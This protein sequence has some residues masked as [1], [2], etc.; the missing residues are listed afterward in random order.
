[1]QC[2]VYVAGMGW[3]GLDVSCRKQAN[4]ERKENVC[5]ISSDFWLFLLWSS[6]RGWYVH[7]VLTRGI[8]ARSI[9]HARARE[10][11]PFLSD[12][13]APLHPSQTHTQAKRPTD[14][15]TILR[16]A[17]NNGNDPDTLTRLDRRTT[18][19]RE[20]HAN[21]PLSLLSATA[22]SGGLGGLDEGHQGRQRARLLQEGMLRTD[23]QTA[24][25]G[26]VSFPVSPK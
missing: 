5:A 19:A 18:S 24:C 8:A 16:H 1:M 21:R 22:A 2:F 13:P 7:S 4:D 25:I 11:T 17:Y 12:Q 10:T 6:S 15:H 23:K 9:T 26:Q 3:V 20:A 14:T